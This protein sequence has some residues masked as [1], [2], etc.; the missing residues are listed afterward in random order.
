MKHWISLKNTFISLECEVSKD[1]SLIL[2]ELTYFIHQRVIFPVNL[3]AHN[4]NIN[5]TIRLPICF[6]MDVY[7]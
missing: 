2:E 3:H 4:S 1:I 6:S 7:V 5:I